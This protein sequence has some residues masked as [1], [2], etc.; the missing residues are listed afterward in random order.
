[1][2]YHDNANHDD[3][4]D[5]AVRA[6]RSQSVPEGLP[7]DLAAEILAALH[8]GEQAANP[9]RTIN[10]KERILAIK[11]TSKIAIAAT[12]LIAFPLSA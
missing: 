7:D 4:L 12:V 11:L 6:Y 3:A 2:V 1:M 8:R 9:S 10:L 5:K